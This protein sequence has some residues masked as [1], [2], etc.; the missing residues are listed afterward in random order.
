MNKMI[1]GAVVA[2][3]GVALLLGGGGTLAVWNAAADAEAGT[4]VAGDLN[5]T[6][7]TGT[8]SSDF[9]G[10]I[11]NIADY[12]VV[13]GETLTYTQELD[14]LLEG[15]QLKAKLALTGAS[16]DNG[17]GANVNIDGPHLTNSAGAVVA[18]TVLT[19][20]TPTEITAKTTFT[21]LASTSGRDSVGATYDFTKIGYLLE[22]QAPTQ[23]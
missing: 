16:A 22:Q 21:F 6:A 8:W 19:E 23:G 10:A 3:V 20:D 17:F 14:V 15:E 11:S 13:P 12:R 18:G 1:K 7:D 4:I 5:L 2:G 9:G